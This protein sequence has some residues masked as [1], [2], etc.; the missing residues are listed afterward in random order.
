MAKITTSEFTIIT[1][2]GKEIIVMVNDKEI[3]QEQAEKLLNIL[4][5]DVMLCQF[6]SAVFKKYTDLGK[7]LAKKDYQ[8]RIRETTFFIGVKEFLEIYPLFDFDVLVNTPNNGIIPLQRE[9]VWNENQKQSLILSILFENSLPNVSIIKVRDDKNNIISY[10][11]IDGKQRLTTIYNFVTNK[12]PI[13]V[14]NRNYFYKELPNILKD[15]FI[16]LSMGCYITSHDYFIGNDVYL[17]SDED[18]IHWFGRV[19]FAGTQQDV[20]HYEKF[21]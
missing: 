3:N 9:L 19:N 11:V 8:N 21:L 20:K 15:K 2:K 14:C 1:E 5:I 17:M 18:K 4:E 16:N 6:E 10:Q 13:I 7:T 12:F